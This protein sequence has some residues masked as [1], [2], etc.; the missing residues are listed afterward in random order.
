MYYIWDTFYRGRAYKRFRQCLSTV[1][2]SCRRGVELFLEYEGT[3]RRYMLKMGHIC[4]KAVEDGN[5]K[6]WMNELIKYGND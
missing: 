1:M 4:Q 2:T 3:L 5:D 6:D